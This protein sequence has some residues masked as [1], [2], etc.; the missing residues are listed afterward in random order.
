MEP[1]SLDVLGWDVRESWGLSEL[2]LASI[3]WVLLG[4]GLVMGEGGVVSLEKVMALADFDSLL[5]SFFL[6]G[7]YGCLT[8]FGGVGGIFLFAEGGMTILLFTDLPV[9]LSM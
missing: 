6:G 1:D 7:S 5:L 3:G 4:S 8:R 2:T 9:Y